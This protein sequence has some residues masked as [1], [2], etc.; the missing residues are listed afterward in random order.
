MESYN[1]WTFVSDCFHLAKCFKVHPY[2][3]DSNYQYFIIFMAQYI[4][5]YGYMAF[6]YLS[7]DGHLDSFHFWLFWIILLGTFKIFFGV[8]PYALISPGYTCRS[9]ISWSYGKSRFNF[10]RNCQLFF[11]SGCLILHLNQQYMRVLICPLSNTC[12]CL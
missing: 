8:W 3:I 11:Q 1:I 9:G 10:L 2:C 5:L 7:V 4:L 12:Y 6:I